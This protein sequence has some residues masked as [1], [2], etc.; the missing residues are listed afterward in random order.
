MDSARLTAYTGCGISFWY[1]LSVD[2]QAQQIFLLTQR[3]PG[4]QPTPVDGGGHDLAPFAQPGWDPN[5]AARL[6]FPT[7]I[8]VGTPRL[9][10]GC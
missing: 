8:P 7:W 4:W 6:E 5:L 10:P 1:A 3:E 2:F 9:V